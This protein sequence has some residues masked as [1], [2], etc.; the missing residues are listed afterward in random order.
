MLSWNGVSVL[1]CNMCMLWSWGCWRA[2]GTYD[3]IAGE[4]GRKV[5][6]ALFLKSEVVPRLRVSIQ[7]LSRWLDAVD[8]DAVDRTWSIQS[9][10]AMLDL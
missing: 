10:V 5:V 8:G 9:R 2:G 6:V 4:V 3:S 7:S 1:G